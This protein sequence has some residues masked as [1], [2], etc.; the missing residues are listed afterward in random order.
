MTI[1]ILH[2]L[3]I[4]P[5]MFSGG[6]IVGGILT[7]GKRDDEVWADLIRDIRNAQ[8]WKGGWGA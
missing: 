1:N 8:N 2:L 3:W 5:L 6:F 4:T 7:I